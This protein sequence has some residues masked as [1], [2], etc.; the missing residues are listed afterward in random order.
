MYHLLDRRRK[1]AG[2]RRHHRE[3][4]PECSISTTVG[5]QICTSGS[6]SSLHTVHRTFNWALPRWGYPRSRFTVPPEGGLSTN[7]VLPDFRHCYTKVTG[8]TGRPRHSRLPPVGMRPLVGVQYKGDK[9]QR[10]VLRLSISTLLYQ[11][12]VT[13]AS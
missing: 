9:V 8:R 12:T 7:T 11:A 2:G 1:Y 5:R 3:V 10:L 13:R 6:T 4:L